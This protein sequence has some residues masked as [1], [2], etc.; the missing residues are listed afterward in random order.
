MSMEY[1]QHDF[2]YKHYILLSSCGTKAHLCVPVSSLILLCLKF[3]S[4]LPNLSQESLTSFCLICSTCQLLDIL[5][6]ILLLNKDNALIA[7][8]LYLFKGSKGLGI[9]GT[10][11]CN[12]T[13]SKE[14]HYLNSVRKAE[15]N[16]STSSVQVFFWKVTSVTGSGFV[17]QINFLYVRVDYPTNFMLAQFAFSV[18]CNLMCGFYFEFRIEGHTLSS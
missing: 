4:G 2:A 10:F 1:L 5:C 3:G 11:A 6:C 13:H 18:C 14:L 15:Y 7:C 8:R 16:T 12:A 17:L 9:P